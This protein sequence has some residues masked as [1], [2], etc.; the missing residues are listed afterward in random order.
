MPQTLVMRRQAEH[1]ERGHD[2]HRV[3]AVAG[4]HEAVT[5][6]ELGVAGA[7][8]GFERTLTDR[9]EPYAGYL[10]DDRAR[11]GEQV[12]VGLGAP[13]VRDRADD[14]LVGCDP[15][16]GAHSSHARAGLVQHRLRVDAVAHDAR[17]A[18]RTRRHRRA[19]RT[20]D[21]DG[22]V[23]E[24]DRRR[25]HETG[26]PLVARPDV[27]LRR[28]DRRAFR[29]RQRADDHAGARGDERGVGVHD[30]DGAGTQLTAQADQPAE[31]PGTAGTEAGGG[32]PGRLERRD[33]GVLP[34]EEVRDAIGR[35]ARCRAL[36]TR[37]E[38]LLGT[39][40]AEALDAPQD[41]CGWSVGVRP[42]SV[43]SIALVV[44]SLATPER[45][46]RSR[47]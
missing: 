6:V 2:A 20:G 34:R 9:D 24:T 12:G 32:D 44:W 37:D 29:P 43:A 18:P 30:V 1:V 21:S 15:E 35:E 8:L 23:V 28:D 5:Q 16:L 33:E 13:D 7:H 38:Q 39:T 26:Q 36:G 10:V 42:R 27:V 46:G 22:R 4:E 17:A 11:R 31:V 25:V 41:A 40:R 14:D 3:G 45:A 47:T 19:H